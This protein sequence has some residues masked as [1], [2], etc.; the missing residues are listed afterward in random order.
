MKQVG[1]FMFST[2]TQAIALYLQIYDIAKYSV[3]RVILYIIAFLLFIFSIWL[4]CKKGEK[5]KSS[6]FTFLEALLL[7]S[8]ALMAGDFTRKDALFDSYLDNNHVVENHT[9]KSS[10]QLFEEAVK[11]VENRE[12][13][14]GMDL[15]RRSAMKGHANAF[16]LLGCLYAK[17]LG[18]EV[19]YE[20]AAYNFAQAG[21]LGAPA[22]SKRVKEYPEILCTG[23]RMVDETISESLG[24]ISSLDSLEILTQIEYN[25]GGNKSIISLWERNKDLLEQLSEKGYYKATSMMYTLAKLTHDLPAC[26]KYARYFKD[27]NVIPDLPMQRHIFYRFLENNLPEMSDTLTRE[28]FNL[29]IENED[30]YFTLGEHTGEAFLRMK[31]GIDNI[32]KYRYNK[33]QFERCEYLKNHSS[34]LWR[35]YASDEPIDGYYDFSRYCLNRSVEIIQQIRD[36]SHPPVFNP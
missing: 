5:R 31:D 1:I 2:M 21:R 23:S 16:D 24:I 6:L 14:K 7:A 15:A 13:S 32:D 20:S 29:L 36:I 25:K 12:F 33:A 30:F 27:E 3:I 34:E 8:V 9:G 35:I 17:G 28:Q 19:D 11:C 4:F 26:K 18:S 10:S 22:F